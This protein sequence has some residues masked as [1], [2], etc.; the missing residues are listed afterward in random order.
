LELEL[1]EYTLGRRYWITIH[2]AYDT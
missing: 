1:V 2:P